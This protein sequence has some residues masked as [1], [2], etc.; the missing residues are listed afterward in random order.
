MEIYNNKSSLIKQL[1]LPAI[2]FL[3]LTG[4][5]LY[6]E[7]I[8]LVSNSFFRPV[9]N[10]SLFNTKMHGVNVLNTTGTIL[11]W[12]TVFHVESESISCGQYK[13]DITRDRRKLNRSDIIIFN[14]RYAKGMIR[15][16]Y[17]SF[18]YIL[19]LTMY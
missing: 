4:Y 9:K 8:S 11:V 18:V 5:Y 16:I 14:A 3:L 17:N 1:L 2:L 6:N 13:C 15:M 7:N 12:T 10:A 19:L